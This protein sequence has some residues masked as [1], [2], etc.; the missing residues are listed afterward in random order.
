[1]GFRATL[2]FDITGGI[3]STIDKSSDIPVTV[4]KLIELNEHSLHCSH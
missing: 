3:N 2:S 1:M 4:K